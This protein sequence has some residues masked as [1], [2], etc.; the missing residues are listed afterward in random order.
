M[1]LRESN[2]HMPDGRTIDAFT[3]SS[4]QGLRARVMTYGAIVLSLDAPDLEGR[5]ADVGLRYEALAGYLDARNF[6]G[7]V[8]GRYANR[9]GD[10][11]F[12]LDGDTFELDANDGPNLLHGGFQGLQRRLG[13]GE[14]FH[15]TS[16]G[17]R[18]P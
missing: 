14:R 3:L 8:I 6:V 10:A 7:G 11:R 1:P 18:P 2:G 16:G 9:I 12:T 4:P 5:A 17:G 15:S 13:D